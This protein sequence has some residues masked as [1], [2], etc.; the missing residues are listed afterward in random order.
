MDES[1]RRGVRVRTHELRLGA[2]RRTDRFVARETPGNVGVALSGGGSRACV[3]G[4]GQLRALRELGLLEKVRAISGV[5]GGT[6]L[7]AAWTFLPDD[8]DDDGFF[9]RVLAPEALIR[10]A[11]GGEDKTCSIDHVDEACFAWPICDGSF[12]TPALLAS[13][14]RAKLRGVELEDRWAHAVGEI[15]FAPVDLFHVDEEG[16]PAAFFAADAE[17]AAEA[18]RHNPA[19]A[20]MRA[21]TVHTRAD[22]TPRPFAIFNTAFVCT[23]RAGNSASAPV[24]GTPYFVGTPSTPPALDSRGEAIG[25]GAVLPFSYGGRLIRAEADDPRLVELELERIY[26]LHDLVGC[27]SAFFADKAVGGAPT[28]PLVP[29]YPRYRPGVAAPAGG[30]DYFLDG[31]ALEN[32]GVAALL[33]WSDID[34]VIAFVNAP[35]ALDVTAD[36]VAMV[37]RQVPPL[38]GYRPFVRGVGY[39]P[40]EGVEAPTIASGTA[41]ERGLLELLPEKRDAVAEGFRNNAVFAAEAFRELLEGLLRRATAGGEKPGV[42]PSAFLQRGVPVIDNPWHGVTGGRRVDVLWVLLSPASQWL[43]RLRPAVARARPSTWPNYPTAWTHLDPESVN[44]LSHFT[45]W[46]VGELRAELD[47]LFAG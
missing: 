7:S 39:R 10:R 12:N 33:A 30:P 4:L 32:T 15:L 23:D 35:A 19:L 34:R 45:S 27:S 22:D 28:Q 46:V 29:Q 11:R 36:G 37:E 41:L 43:G 18:R 6:W 9:G 14:H 16:Q 38:F 26:A 42:G 3:A 13:G 20:S 44:L 21:L 2:A 47:E 17:A 8:R 31:G 40:Y 5:S 25:G 24:Q 1:E